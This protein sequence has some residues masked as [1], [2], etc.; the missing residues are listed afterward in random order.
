MP[1]AQASEENETTGGDEELEKNGVFPAEK[2]P[3]LLLLVLILFVFLSEQFSVEYFAPKDHDEQA[4]QHGG[5]HVE[6]EVSV[7]PMAYTVVQPR[8]VMIH[9]QHTPIT[10]DIFNR[11]IFV[12]GKILLMYL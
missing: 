2:D 4:A 7:I 1:N 3:R 11:I 10:I 9:F 6:K 8:A 5:H 12:D